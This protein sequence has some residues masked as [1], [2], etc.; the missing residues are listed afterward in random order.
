MTL[1]NRSY[2]I[3][4]DLDRELLIGGGGLLPRRGLHRDPALQGLSVVRCLEWV[5][6]P[7]REL[8]TWKVD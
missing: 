6:L 7:L 3:D 5:S 1:F 4:I 8:Y 2:Q